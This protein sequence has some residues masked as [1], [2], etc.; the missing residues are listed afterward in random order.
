MQQKQAVVRRSGCSADG[1]TSVQKR[2]YAL[3]RC[4]TG[5]DAFPREEKDCKNNKKPV[6]AKNLRKKFLQK[7]KAGALLH[8]SVKK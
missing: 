8:K 5:N 1:Y 7:Y 3:W 6:F 4:C 2:V